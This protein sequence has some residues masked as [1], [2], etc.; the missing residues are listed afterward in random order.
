MFNNNTFLVFNNLSQGNLPPTEPRQL[1]IAKLA[2]GY[3]YM[4]L[5]ILYL[6]ILNYHPIM[7]LSEDAL[8]VT[9]TVNNSD[10]RLFDLLETAAPSHID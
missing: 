4:T 1:T 9:L 3:I 8:F 10:G 2:F 5:Y 7:E 6:Y